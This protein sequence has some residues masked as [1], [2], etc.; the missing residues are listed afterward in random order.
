MVET[1][2]QAP[3]VRPPLAAAPSVEELAARFRGKDIVIV[4]NGPTGRRLYSELG[5]PLW[6]VN[7]GWQWH[8]AAELCWMMDDLEGPAWDNVVAKSADPEPVRYLNLDHLQTSVQTGGTTVV[9]KP[10]AHWEEITKRCPVPILTA[11]AYPDKFPQT[12]TYPLK[13]VLVGN[14]GRRHYIAETVCFAAAWALHIGVKSISFGG[15]D[16]GGIR[17]AERACLEYWIGRLEE[18]GI[19]CKVFPGSQLLNAGP[20]NARNRH[21]PGIYGIREWELDIPNQYELCDFPN[22]TGLS[23]DSDERLG[24]EALDALMAEPDIKSVL[25]VGCGNGATARFL[26]A[27]GRRVVGVDPSLPGDSFNDQ[28]NGGQAWL[29]KQDYLDPE[30]PQSETFDAIWCCHVLEHVDDPQRLLRKCFDDLRDGG[31][32]AITVPPA[33]HAIVGGHFSFWNAGQLLYHLVRA[34]F[35]CRNARIKQY[36]YNISI[37][38]RKSAVPAGVIPTAA[39]YKVEA[40]RDYL[41]EA[42]EWEYGTFNGDIHELNWSK[43][44]QPSNGRNPSLPRSPSGLR[45][46]WRKL[47]AGTR[48]TALALSAPM[49]PIKACWKWCA[50][51]WRSAMF[52]P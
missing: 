49:R 47:S 32:L 19:P 28:S 51:S 33:Q 52:G 11:K 26:S 38:A 36:G 35:D 12:V 43:S 48:N 46:L 42:L 22:G 24:Y 45:F 1:A 29:L 21:V 40:L 27:A 15:C 20:L 18:A 30:L 16:Y 4:G 13:D 5:L 8:P 9:E 37:L 44:W 2:M 17:P 3:P 50:A 23:D 14:G 6:V 7:G 10:R 31:L 25:D 34:G 39:N 41:P